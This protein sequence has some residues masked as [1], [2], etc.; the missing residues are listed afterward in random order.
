M[1]AC[2]SEGP[3]PA[4][5]RLCFIT[6]L[7]LAPDTLQERA[8]KP[9]RGDAPPQIDGDLS[10]AAGNRLNSPITLALAAGLPCLMLREKNLPE[11]R[12]IALAVELGGL[13]R[14]HG[15]RLVVHSSAAA[16]LASGAW[17]LHLTFEAFRRLSLQNGAV[18]GLKNKGLNIGVS[19]HSVDEA[20]FCRAA[21]ADLIMA[22]HIF[23]SP[24]KA[25]LPGRGLDFLAKAA[26]VGPPV[27]AVGGLNPERAGLAFAAGAAGI[28]VRSAWLSGDAGKITREFLRAVGQ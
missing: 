8:A 4:I 6:D 24:C 9:R 23:E 5:P 1:S 14:R 2:E 22:G 16:A 12:L 21:G 28:C 19:V 7:A 11:D 20:A 13:A 25:G 27:W 15:G 10:I 17:G 18:A 26:E 3:R